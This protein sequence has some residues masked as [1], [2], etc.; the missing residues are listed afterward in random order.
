MTEVPL[1]VG[2]AKKTH[3][4]AQL[5]GCRTFLGEEGGTFLKDFIY[6]FLERGEGRVKERERYNNV[7]LPLTCLPLG[8]W[9]TTQAGALTGN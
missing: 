8:I 7:W 1:W 4:S 6:L 9:P 3:P 2:V 5:P